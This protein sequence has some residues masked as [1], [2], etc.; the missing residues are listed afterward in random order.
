[1]PF[2]I[3]SHHSLSIVKADLNDF[4]CCVQRCNSWAFVTCKGCSV[5][6]CFDC[7]WNR[8]RHLESSHFPSQPLSGKLYFNG[9]KFPI[10]IIPLFL[11]LW[12]NVCVC[13]CVCVYI[14]RHTRHAYH[15]LQLCFTTLSWQYH[16]F[17]SQ[18]TWGLK[19]LLSLH[20]SQSANCSWCLFLSL[21]DYALWVLCYRWNY[22][23]IIYIHGHGHNVC[24]H[25]MH[26]PT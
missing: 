11:T 21:E 17:S 5:G 26:T 13:V 18:P 8:I 6:K 1:M 15:L 19:S 14:Q 20:L 3:F 2:R 22:M 10:R 23:C 9:N 25:T 16:C 12:G 7:S 24:T 4:S